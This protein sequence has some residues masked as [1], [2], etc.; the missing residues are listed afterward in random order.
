MVGLEAL[1]AACSYITLALLLG[2]LVAAGFLLPDGAPKNLPHSLLAGAN[3][4]LLIFLAVALAALVIQGVKL[5]RGFPSV[6]LL[7]R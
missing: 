5:E 6:E 4:A 7:W 2:Q 3:A 1:A